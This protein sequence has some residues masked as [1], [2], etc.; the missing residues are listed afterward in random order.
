MVQLFKKRYTSLQSGKFLFQ[1]ANFSFCRICPPPFSLGVFSLFLSPFSPS[2]FLEKL[3]Y[4]LFTTL[5]FFENLKPSSTFD[6]SS[7]STSLRLQKQ[8]IHDLLRCL[9]KFPLNVR[10][11]KLSFKKRPYI[12][13]RCSKLHCCLCF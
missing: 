10:I 6:I 7:S 2:V 8:I 4:F 11:G 3:M 13:L 12:P 5:S 1:L 9:V